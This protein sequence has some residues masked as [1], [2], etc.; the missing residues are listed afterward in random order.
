MLCICN[1]LRHRC[2][3]G[4]GPSRGSCGRGKGERRRREERGTSERGREGR[5]TSGRRE[6]ARHPSAGGRGTGHPGVGGRGAGHPRGGAR[7]IQGEAWDIRAWEGHRTCEC[8]TRE[9]DGMGV[10][11]GVPMRRK[12]GKARKGREGRVRKDQE[13]RGHLPSCPY[14]F[15]RSQLKLP[16]LFEVARSF[17]ALR[18]VAWGRIT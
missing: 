6:G 10:P 16:L 4:W 14:P 7:D 13:R 17:G 3:S 2:R 5:R 1:P 9:G 12:V 15:S 8:G 11:L 18:S